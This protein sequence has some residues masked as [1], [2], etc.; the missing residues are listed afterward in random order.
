LACSSLVGLRARCL[1]AGE[2]PGTIYTPLIG[3][4]SSVNGHDHTGHKTG[5]FL[6]YSTAARPPNPRTHRIFPAAY[7]R[8]SCVRAASRW[9]RLGQQRA[10]LVGDKKAGAMALTRTRPLR[11]AR[12]AIG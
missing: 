1:S 11:N 7:G 12:P 2:L 3:G 4:E 6:G 5:G 9:R 8:E 10:V